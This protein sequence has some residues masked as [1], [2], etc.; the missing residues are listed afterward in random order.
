VLTIEAEASTGKGGTVATRIASSPVESS[1]L[2]PASLVHYVQRTKERVILR[3]AAAGAGR[4]SED[5]YF[6]RVRPRSVLCLPIVRQG[7]VVGLLYLENNV[8]AGAFT[9]ERLL[10]LELCATQ[11]AISMENARLLA[12]E[13][14]AIQVRDEFLCVAAHELFTPMTSL[15]LSLESLR[16]AGEGGAA[17]DP[18]T[19]RRLVEMA[20]RQGE[21]L[22][23]LVATLLDVSRIETGRLALDPE[24]MDLAALAREVVVRFE[25]DFER[26][27]TAVSITCDRPVTGRWDRSRLDQVVTNLLSNAHKFGA[28]KPIEIALGGE[29]G[30]AWV[31]VRDHGIGV[32]PAR[33]PFIFERFERAV[34]TKHYGGLGLGLYISRRIVEAHGGSI[35]VES[36]PGDGAT[37]TVE[38]PRTA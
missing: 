10:A 14:E 3:D 11:A 36:R 4:F 2:V 33:Q 13:R 22:T 34:P 30:A 24:E 28:G 7:E 38:L 5:P 35:R 32:D 20:H 17:A 29:G 27:R 9:A 6:A 26:S 18:A 8:L 23:R 21:R 25:T 31:R 16:R 19:A 1:P 12:Q 37:F 15:T